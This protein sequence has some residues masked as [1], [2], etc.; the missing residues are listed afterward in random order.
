MS[1]VKKSGININNYV[2]LILHNRNERK[3]REK[4]NEKN[5]KAK[6]L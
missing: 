6:K 4:K 2:I 1:K 3:G 5:K